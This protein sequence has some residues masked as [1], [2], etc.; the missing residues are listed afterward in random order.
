MLASQAFTRAATWCRSVMPGRGWD[1]R[2]ADI[3]TL[4]GGNLTQCMQISCR[5]GIINDL[6]Q[7][8]IW[9]CIKFIE[10]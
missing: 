4:G 9:L 7:L 5:D 3:G 6:S 10:A 2:R 1:F 8:A